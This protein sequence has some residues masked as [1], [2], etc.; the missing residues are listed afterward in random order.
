MPPTKRV[1]QED[2]TSTSILKDKLN[3]LQNPGNGMRGR[4]NGASAL[5]NGSS[6]KEVVSQ[7]DSASTHGGQNGQSMMS[8]A[9]ED[10]A[11][12]QGYR[13]TYRL[14]APSSFKNPLSHVVLSHGIGKYSP[15]MARHKAKRRVPKE[16]LAMSVRKNFNALAVNETEVIVDLLYK[17]KTQDKAFRARFAPPPAKK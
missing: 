11:L 10:P 8:W 2:S 9:S 17:A 7:A 16:Q 4:R 13:R 6:L 12:L 1:L 15:T 14:D 3:A 5:G